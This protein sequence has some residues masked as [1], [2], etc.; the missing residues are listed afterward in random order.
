MGRSPSARLSSAKWARVRRRIL[1]RDGW[2]CR[3]CDR[4]GKLQVHHITPLYKGGEP[5]A[6]ENLVALCPTCHRIEHSYPPTL[7]TEFRDKLRT[8]T[9]KDNT[10]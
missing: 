2:R 9:T 3:G 7:W 4:P 5:Y 1:D 6:P 8:P 10:Q